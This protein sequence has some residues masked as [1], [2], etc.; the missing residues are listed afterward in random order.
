MPDADR[1]DYERAV[2]QSTNLLLQHA[3]AVIEHL[4]VLSAEMFKLVI[5]SNNLTKALE[6]HDSEE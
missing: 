6:D 1:E 4:A 3:V 2:I 5:E